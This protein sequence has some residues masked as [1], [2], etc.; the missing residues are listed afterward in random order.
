LLQLEAQYGHTQFV[1]ADYHVSGALS[2][3]DAA[4][5]GNYYP[6]SG[7]PSVWFDGYDNRIGGGGNMY[8][9]YAP[10]VANH[11]ANDLCK[12]SIIATLVF[13]TGNNTGTID[14][15]ITIANGETVANPRGQHRPVLRSP[16]KR[17]LAHDCARH[18][19]GS[20]FGRG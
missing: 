6:F 16:R 19:A 5:R 13:N 9:I 10:I 11:L 12:L 18:A 3:P 14:A 2:N 4:A 8:P 7:A 17:R 15:T 1:H 20:D